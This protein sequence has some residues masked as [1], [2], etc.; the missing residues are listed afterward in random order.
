MKDVMMHGVEN[1][2]MYN[3]ESFD[4]LFKKADDDI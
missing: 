4:A 3:D 1:L 2:S